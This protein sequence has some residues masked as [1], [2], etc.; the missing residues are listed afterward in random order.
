MGQTLDQLEDLDLVAEIQRRGRLIQQQQGR[1]LCQRHGDPGAL[2]LPAGHRGQ[3]TVRQAL[4]VGGGHRLGHQPL[5]LLR[6]LTQRAL[7]GLTTETHQLMYRYPL[8]RMRL[9]RQQRDA[10]GHFAPL[11]GVN[12]LAFQQHRA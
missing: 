5:I 10:L 12:V 8:G 1:L 6:P 4:D 9:L 11:V 7:I 2:A 3:L